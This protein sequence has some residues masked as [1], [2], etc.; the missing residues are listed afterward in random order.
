[1][2][3]SAHRE[4]VAEWGGVLNTGAMGVSWYRCWTIWL[5]I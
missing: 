5:S 3:E 4:R 2:R 1:M